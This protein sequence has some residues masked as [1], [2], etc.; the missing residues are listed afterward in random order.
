[1]SIRYNERGKT[2]AGYSAEELQNL[3][4]KTDWNRVDSMTDEELDA[5]AKSDPDNPPLPE[6]FF[7]HAK[8]M[9]LE[10]FMP[11]GKGKVSLRLD[12]EVLEYFK[13]NGPGYQTRINAVLKS[14]V[15]H[16]GKRSSQKG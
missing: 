16:A 15:S 12:K 9:R 6:D 8:Q 14:Y 2:I 3:P 1:M 5:N 11:K 4:S 13:A 10:D 7:L